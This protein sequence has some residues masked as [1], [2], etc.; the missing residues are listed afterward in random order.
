MRVVIAIDPGLTTGLAVFSYDGT[1]DPIMQHA[2][3]YSVWEFVENLNRAVEYARSVDVVPDIVC[4]RFIINAQTVRNSQAPY[5]IEQI[6][7]LKYV[8][9]TLKLDPNA[10]MFQSPADAKKMFPNEALKKLKY[11]VVGSD[12]HD[13]DAI[14]H[15]LI[16]LVKTGWVP[17]ALLT[18]LIDTTKK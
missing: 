5:S 3:E 14:R 2:G 10:I 8:M 11:W 1:T 12:G 17:K 13:K 6:G 15:A 9:Y 4:E 16:R 18:Q 7:I